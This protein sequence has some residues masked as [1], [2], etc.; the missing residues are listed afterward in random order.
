MIF[1]NCGSRFGQ[2]PDRRRFC[3]QNC[4]DEYYAKRDESDAETTAGEDYL[5]ALQEE[6]A[7]GRGLSNDRK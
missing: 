2:L 7:E 6:N 3:S 5:S 4:S 1:K